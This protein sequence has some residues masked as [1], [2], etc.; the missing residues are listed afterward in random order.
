MQLLDAPSRPIGVHVRTRPVIS[1]LPIVHDLH[2]VVFTDGVLSAGERYGE[3]LDVAGFVREQLVAC[4]SPTCA[5]SLA[6]RLLA[7]AVALDRGR[8]GDDV[9]VVVLSVVPRQEMDDVR[10]LSVRFPI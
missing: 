7:Q 1:E 3:R 8:P 9:T 2:V 5:R 10:R 6:D 4:P